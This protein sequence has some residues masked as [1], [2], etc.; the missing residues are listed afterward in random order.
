MLWPFAKRRQATLS[1]CIQGALSALLRETNSRF[2]HMYLP[3][4]GDDLGERFAAHYPYFILVLTRHILLEIVITRRFKGAIFSPDQAADAWRKGLEEVLQCRSKT[5]EEYTQKLKDYEL[6]L[7]DYD[8]AIVA[9]RSKD[10]PASTFFL[11]TAHFA[12]KITDLCSEERHTVMEIAFSIA[13]MVKHACRMA[14]RLYRLT[15]Q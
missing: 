5:H 11:I 15:G 4:I 8:E 12:D 14:P 2:I 9:A 6:A 13:D 7:R 3:M 1:E 10:L